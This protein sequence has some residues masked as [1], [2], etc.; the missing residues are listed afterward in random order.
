MPKIRR[1]LLSVYDKK[2][3]IPF[4]KGLARCGIRILST[5]KTARLLKANG[6]AVQEVSEYTGY[7][8]LLDGRVKTLHPKIHAAILADRSNHT[9]MKTLKQEGIEPIDLV[10]VDLYPFEKAKSIG[11]ID[12]GGVTLLRAAAKNSQYVTVVPGADFYDE[13]LSEL[14]RN[15]TVREATNRKLAYQAFLRTSRYDA[16]IRDFFGGKEAKEVLPEILSL[17]FRKLM[18]L[19]YGENP[20]Q[21]GALY[22]AAASTVLPGEISLQGKPWPA[23]ISLQGRS[24]S[25]NN[26]LDLD[27][28]YRIVS[29][30]KKPAVAIVKHA[31]PCGVAAAKTLG[32][33]FQKAWACDTESAFGGVVGVNRAL[34]R[35]FAKQILESGFLEVIA[36]PKIEKEALR[37]LRRRENL[38]LVPFHALYAR[39]M[40]PDR[41]LKQ[42]SEGV[43]LVQTVDREGVSA[44]RLRCVTKRKPTKEEL[45]SLLFA[46]KVAKHVRSNAIVIAKEEATVGIGGGQPSRVGAVRLALSKAGAKAEGAVLASDGFFPFPDNVEV[47]ASGGIRAIIQPGGSIRDRE[48][49]GACN[50]RKIAL[51]FTGVRHFKH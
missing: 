8:E 17:T 29:D 7:P 15:T 5:G 22:G 34:D 18:M 30:F 2:G 44:S 43:L 3:I 28:A 46:F 31:S 47:A 6:I 39:G 23:S 37:L 27:T 20:H 14:K 25:F 9:H 38:R 49:I 21:E 33:A 19:R 13:I 16:A 51:V 4:A 1:A 26:L 40:F 48:V 11:L 45:S 35:N 36:F 12:V 41:D 42:I 10:A 32:E 50:D 24:L